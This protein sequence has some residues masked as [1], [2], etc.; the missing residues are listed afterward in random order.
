MRHLLKRA[1]FNTEKSLDQETCPGLYYR[2][3]EPQAQVCN[4]TKSKIR[5]SFPSQLFIMRQVKNLIP[6]SPLLTACSLLTV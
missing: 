2:T 6:D 4:E 3:H 1:L 5:I